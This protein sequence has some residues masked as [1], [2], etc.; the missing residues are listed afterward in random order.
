MLRWLRHPSAAL[1][2]GFALMLLVVAT[3]LTVARFERQDQARVEDTFAVDAQI[4]AVTARLQDVEGHQRNFLVTGEAGHLVAMARTR[5]ALRADVDELSAATA[6]NPRQVAAL[7]RLRPLMDERLASLDRGVALRRAQGLEAASAHVR[8]GR[9]LALMEGVKREL[10]SMRAEEQRLLKLRRAQAAGTRRNLRIVVGLGMLGLLAVTAYAVLYATRQLQRVRVSRDELLNAN[11]RLQ[12]EGK[13]RG[14]AEAELRQMQKMEAVGHLTGGIAH[15]FNNMLLVVIGNLELARQRL[16]TSPERAEAAIASAIGGAERAAALTARLLAFSRQQPLSP[17]PVEPNRLVSGMSDLL[18]RSLGE[19]LKIETVLG[20]GVWRVHV[21]A[22]RLENALLNLCVNA[23]D[24]M[25]GGGR[26]TIETSNAY[27]DSAYAAAHGELRE[28]QY[29]LIAVS[30]TGCGMTE[31]V[32]AR[33]F[34]PFF[35]T[36]DVGQGTGLGLSQVFGFVKQSGGHIKIYSEPGQGTSVKI[37]LPRRMAAA[38]SESLPVAP[39]STAQDEAPSGRGETVLVVEDDDKVRQITVEV[40]LGLGYDVL[41]AAS[42][43][44][45]LSV[46]SDPRRVDLLLTDIVM[47]G[48]TGRALAEAAAK[49]RPDLPVLYMT[50]YSRNAVVHNGVLDRGVAFLQKPFTGDQLAGKV[51]QVLNEPEAA[52]SPPA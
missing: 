39:S 47:P 20:A 38:E 36:K 1:T 50:G 14:R 13:A 10:R 16:R 2:I 51:R 9:G 49:L 24:A 26:L 48:M 40:L 18:H 45:A 46:L 44:A 41:E 7:R 43:P 25:P 17:V 15:D 8:L 28:G 19:H 22:P 23:R 37:Y 3:A 27:L 34:D 30:D 35:T 4:A 52:R 32:V 31:D 42:G 11:A 12:E 6:D 5:A 29:V 33:A 21:D